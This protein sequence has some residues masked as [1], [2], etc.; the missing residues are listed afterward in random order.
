MPNHARP[1]SEPIVQGIMETCL[2]AEDLDA[3]AEFYERVVG[4]ELMSRSEGLRVLFRTGP[5]VLLLFDPA[6]S[7]RTDRGV[8]AHGATGPGHIAFRVDGDQVGA[9]RERLRREGVPI[10]REVEWENGGRSIY[11]RDPAGNS[12]EFATVAVWGL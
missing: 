5:H 9:W 8:P 10:E 4:L 6:K 12:V 2:Y 7:R 3:A 1:P 11:V